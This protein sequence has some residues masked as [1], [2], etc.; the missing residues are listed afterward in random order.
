[1]EQQLFRVD[2]K[3]TCGV[4]KKFNF[5]GKDVDTPEPFIEEFLNV[6]DEPQTFG[7]IQAFL[8]KRGIVYKNSDKDRSG[9]AHT[10]NRMIKNGRIRKHKPDETYR[11]PHY[12]TLSKSTFEAALD[13]HLMKTESMTFMFRPEGMRR[14]DIDIESEFPLP[15]FSQMEQLVRNL[16]TRLG[17]Q[18]LYIL[19]TSYVRPNDPNKSSSDYEANRNA[20]LKNALSYHNPVES[21]LD[22]H[23]KGILGFDSKEYQFEPK[24]LLKKIDL[25][26]IQIQKIYP[27]IIQNMII[28][29][30]NLK[31][32][33]D[34]MREDYLNNERYTRL[35]E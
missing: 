7:Q 24:L 12:T 27:N 31:K 19:L 32:V 6:Q 29:E 2:R 16:I 1:M 11:F 28:T 5:N 3:S 17:V 33:K 10:L 30:N 18:T 22:D 14:G 9:L 25:I 15:K 4:R 23:I 20:W 34:L 8:K 13:G 35:V 26:K 21:S